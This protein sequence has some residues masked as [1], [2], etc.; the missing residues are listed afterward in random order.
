MFCSTLSCVVQEVDIIS[1]LA[2]CSLKTT[3]LLRRYDLSVY[4][5][6]LKI[7]RTPC[8]SPMPIAGCAGIYATFPTPWRIVDADLVLLVWARR[9]DTGVHLTTHS[10]QER[11][12]LS[13]VQEA[14]LVHKSQW[15]FGENRP[16]RIDHGIL[17]SL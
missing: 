2:M 10:F 14:G 17:V 8:I 1:D 15:T 16:S 6:P 5:A 12:A 9:D 4:R 3:T 7:R 11:I 13:S